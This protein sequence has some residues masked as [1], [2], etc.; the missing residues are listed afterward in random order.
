MKLEK[1]NLSISVREAKNLLNS[2]NPIETNLT[3]SVGLLFELGSNARI[4]RE[5]LE[6]GIKIEKGLVDTL[7]GVK[8]ADPN[9]IQAINEA[10]VEFNKKREELEETTISITLNKL[11]IQEDMK[12]SM[13]F[14]PIFFQHWIPYSDIVIEE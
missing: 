4:L 13:R 5:A 7:N 10:A 11:H 2:L 6:P 14:P 3:Y 1:L 8:V 9:N 12:K